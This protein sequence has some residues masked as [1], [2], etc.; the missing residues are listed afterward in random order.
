[1]CFAG[2][3]SCSICT[4]HSIPNIEQ[5]IQEPVI[6]VRGR[7]LM[8]YCHFDLADSDYLSGSRRNP[9]LCGPKGAPPGTTLD[10]NTRV[11]E[12]ESVGVGVRCVK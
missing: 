1:M 2:F 9:E 5:D 6:K 3:L 7:S 8:P 10:P 4:L 12:F 11:I